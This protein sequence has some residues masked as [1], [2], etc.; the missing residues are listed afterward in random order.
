VRKNWWLGSIDL[1]LA[2]FGALM[3]VAHGST[4]APFVCA[5]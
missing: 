1:V 4:L 3:I 5:L 2:A